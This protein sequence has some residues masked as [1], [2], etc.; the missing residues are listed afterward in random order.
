MK[1]SKSFEI[2]AKEVF[3]DCT[4]DNIVFENVS[5]L[6]KAQTNCGDKVAVF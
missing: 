1:N 6:S 5:T 3:G 2:L 4:W